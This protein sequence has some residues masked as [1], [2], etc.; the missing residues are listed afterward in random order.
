METTIDNT[1]RSVPFRF[2]GNA[3]E[4]FRIWIVNL[5]LS[6]ITLGIYSA[7]AKVRNKRYFYNHTELD[8]STFDYHADP[9]AILKGRLIAFGVF[10][11]L[12]ATVNFQ[13]LLEPVFMLLLLLGLPWLMVRALT[14]NARNSSY[15]NIRFD[16]RSDYRA[17]AKVYILYPLLIIVTFG[18]AYPYFDY[19]HRD[20]IVD[21][22]RYGTADFDFDAQASQFYAIYLKAFATAIIAAVVMVFIIP[23][24]HSADPGAGGDSPQEVPQLP[25]LALLPMF[26]FI[27]IYMLAGIY[28]KTATTNAV[29]NH[30]HNRGYRFTSSLRIGR[31]FWIY[32]S[33][34]LAILASAGLL[35]P[36]AKV[37]LM[38]YRM[39]HLTLEAPDA[40]DHFVASE[41]ERVAATGEELAG[42]YDIDLGL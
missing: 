25:S 20:F 1:V 35:I 34:L 12:N 10:M 19:R 26:G 3:G 33:N 38:H 39:D 32:I 6:I 21:N 13:P 14:F 23:E 18:L 8:G 36:W 4:Y 30:A 22:S 28:I 7:W 24:A 2:H 16:F 42:I 31:M 15:R 5:V 9:M 11:G 27:A 41:Q 17:A 40:L 29:F 37:R